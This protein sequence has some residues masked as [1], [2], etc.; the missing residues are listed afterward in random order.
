[1]AYIQPNTDIYLLSGIN[2]TNNYEDTVYFESKGSQYAYMKSM[3]KQAFTAQSYQRHSK[4]TLRILATADKIFD[5]N[6]LMFQNKSYG[7]K[8]F[9]AFITNCEYINDNTTEI[10]YEIDEIQTWFWDLNLGKCLVERETTESDNL[11]ENTVPETLELGDL[12]INDTHYFDL[13]DTVIL[14]I[15]LTDANGNYPNYNYGEVYKGIVNDVFLPLFFETYERNETGAQQLYDFI[16]LMASKGYAE[17]IVSINI[18]PRFALEDAFS[19][20]GG[21]AGTHYAS[22]YVEYSQTPTFEGFLPKNKKLYSYPFNFLTVSNNQGQ[23]REYHWE[24][25]RTLIP[26][27]FNLPTVGFQ[28]TGCV[29]TNPTVR[30][31]PDSYL[32]AGINVDESVV[33]SNFTPVPWINDAYQAYLAQ[34]KASIT[35][36][37]LGSVIAAGFNASTGNVA[38]FGMS[39]ISFG[40]TLAS[41]ADKSNLPTTPI[42][43]VQCDAL[44]LILEQV[45]FEF[46]NYCLKKEYAQKIDNYFSAYG[47]ALN[48]IKVPNINKRPYWNFTKTSNCLLYGSCPADSKAF[49]ANQ[50]NKGIRFWKSNNPEYFGNYTLD[51]SP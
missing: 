18:V 32:M 48:E 20:D 15:S 51:N 28:I 46:K 31:S 12:I 9:Y 22:D 7:S 35:T 29:Y 38:G 11:Y 40:K 42:N 37:L 3:T 8:W 25:F 16:T 44:N 6:Y 23:V 2:W 36:S 1:M 43:L 10:T 17:N 19:K 39:A 45:R 21:A 13:N 24:D 27:E 47:Y 49:I 5:C 34:N 4:N 41:A 30:C 33:I 26:S 14:L 50:F